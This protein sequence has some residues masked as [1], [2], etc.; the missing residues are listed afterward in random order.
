MSTARALAKFVQLA[1]LSQRFLLQRLSYN[2]VR[3]LISID[4]D[5]TVSASED[6]VA[7]LLLEQEICG[8]GINL[9]SGIATIFKAGPVHKAL[10][11]KLLLIYDLAPDKTI[12]VGIASVCRFTVDEA[13]ASERLTSRYCATNEMPRF[14]ASWQ[15]VDAFCSKQSPAGSLLILNAVIQAGR[16][17]PPATG[18]VAISVNSKSK[19]TF[20]QLG[21][22]TH[23]CRKDE[24]VV[25]LKLDDI[26]LPR[27]RER[28]RVGGPSLSTICWRAGATP[29]TRDRRIA[30]C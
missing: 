8:D 10:Q 19:R 18:V 1:M 30:R 22:S 13:L 6:P 23:T 24:H 20:E 14:D 16:M 21:F 7:R 17:R 4:E 28:L 11:G 25:W 27:I 3:R 29:A 9:T 12:L 5:E 2:D 26:D 15:L